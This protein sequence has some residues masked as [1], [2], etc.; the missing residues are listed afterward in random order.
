MGKTIH[1][2]DKPVLRKVKHKE[3][4]LSYLYRKIMK[5]LKL[6]FP[7]FEYLKNR[8][9]E[10]EWSSHRGGYIN[11]V[12]VL[13]YTNNAIGLVG[14]NNGMKVI[15]AQP[16]PYNS[17]VNARKGSIIVRHTSGDLNDLTPKDVLFNFGDHSELS[18]GISVISP[19]DVITEKAVMITQEDLLIVPMPTDSMGT[20]LQP[21]TY[22]P[23]MHQYVNPLSLTSVSDTFGD[24]APFS[25]KIIMSA[26]DTVNQDK[27]FY[28]VLGGNMLRATV[29]DN[30]YSKMYPRGYFEI[31]TEGVGDS[32][33]EDTVVRVS[34]PEEDGKLEYEGTTYFVGY[35]HHK[36]KDVYNT[37]IEELRSSVSNVI[38][39]EEIARLKK[40]QKEEIRRLHEG[41]KNKIDEL[42][43]EI[44][45]LKRE[46][47]GL[48]EVIDITEQR[49]N[50]EAARQEREHETRVYEYKERT[51][52]HTANKASTAATSEKWKAASVFS[53][54]VVP[55]AIPAIG[56]AGVIAWKWWKN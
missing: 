25:G 18:K 11:T 13:N 29:Q 45:A 36:V 2:K 49:K 3:T 32:A 55:L 27:T 4:L 31:K 38:Y 41:N 33:T 35:E 48:R 5:G 51:A 44:A 17:M 6:I 40:Q 12:Q 37:Y 28:C 30:K 52:H 50:R 22:K 19:E 54:Y 39:D 26:Y 56:A 46:K 43:D 53:K 20:P 42:E 16:F 9:S 47:R 34:I 24:G 14:T 23:D 21:G 15:P 10:I 1:D 7:N 8:V